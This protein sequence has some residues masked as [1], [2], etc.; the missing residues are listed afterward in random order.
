MAFSIIIDPDTT[1][2]RL[3]KIASQAYSIGD[4]VDVN[5]GSSTI[6]VVPSTA[7]STT[8]SITG[9]A[10]SAQTSSD[11][12]LLIA[13][14]S[15]RQT[16]KASALNTTNAAHNNQRM[17]W[18]AGETVNNTGSDVTGNTGIFQQIGV[19]DS[20]HVLGKLL[21]TSVS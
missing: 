1:V 14:I 7:S 4:L 9:I 2:Y 16:I 20:T 3:V 17:I 8:E 19:L 10:M 21:P 5:R 11:T 13:L 18:G 15:P 6:D 12:Q